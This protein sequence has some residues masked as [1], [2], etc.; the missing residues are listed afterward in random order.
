VGLGSE[1]STLKVTEPGFG[2]SI[3]SPMMFPGSSE[4]S[5]SGSGI[6]GN[7]RQRELSSL[8]DMQTSQLRER[9]YFHFTIKLQSNKL[10]KLLL[11]SV[12]YRV[13]TY[14][15]LFHQISYLVI[16][17]NQTNDVKHMDKTL[18]YSLNI[19]S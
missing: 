9:I 11:W 12:I 2:A 15:I 8:Y 16:L 1:M 3:K 6:S 17:N 5:P 14:I 18:I 10:I 7:L 13:L 4:I 19:I